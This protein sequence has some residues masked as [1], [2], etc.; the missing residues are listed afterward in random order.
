MSSLQSNNAGR[1]QRNETANEMARPALSLGASIVLYRTRIER[2]AALLDQL[3]EQGAERVYL[4][5]NSPRSFDTFGDWTPPPRVVVIRTGI[6]LGYGGGHN[7]AIDDSVLRHEYHLICNPDIALGENTL[8]T[9]IR[10]LIDHPQVGL[11]M[12][13]VVGTDSRLHY[14]CKRSPLLLD[15][16]ATLVS[17]TQWG[18]RRRAD[19]EM[20]HRDYESAMQV[21]CLSGCFMLFRASVLRKLRGFDDGYFLYFEDFDLSKRAAALGENLYWPAAQVVH[22]HGRAHRHSWRLRLVF[23]RS[24][25]RYFNK[26][27]W[28]AAR[29]IAREQGSSR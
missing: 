29:P 10:A 4:V 27:G 1:P 8:A 28:F 18:A 3:L 24:A 13:R 20:R 11:C 26:W 9:L 2:V 23:M 14:M 21:E 5:D 15:F 17:T 7:I 19:Y 16:V 25:I 22:E 6:N 12:P